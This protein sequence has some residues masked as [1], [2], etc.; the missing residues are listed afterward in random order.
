MFVLK[1][2]VAAG[3]G[4]TRRYDAQKYSKLF[5]NTLSGGLYE[6]TLTGAQK[7]DT[8]TGSALPSLPFSLPERGL[9]DENQNLLVSPENL[10]D[11]KNGKIQVSHFLRVRCVLVEGRVE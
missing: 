1:A 10:T 5:V 7:V 9:K 8:I 11:G 4:D 3:Y 2:V 6:V